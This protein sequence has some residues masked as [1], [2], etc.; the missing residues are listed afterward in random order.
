M[1]LAELLNEEWENY[2][3]DKDVKAVSVPNLQLADLATSVPLYDECDV[4]VVHGT[5]ERVL[6]LLMM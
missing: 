5:D 1:F 4:M 2:G 6:M 3:L